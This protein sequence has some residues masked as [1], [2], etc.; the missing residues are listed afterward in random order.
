[1]RDA[2]GVLKVGCVVADDQIVGIN[3]LAHGSVAQW[4]EV[5][6]LERCAA[7]AKQ[8][9]HAVSVGIV[10]RRRAGQVVIEVLFQRVGQLVLFCGA[11]VTVVPD[12]HRSIGG[13]HFRTC[14]RL[15]AQ[16]GFQKQRVTDA[17]HTLDRSAVRRAGK[18]GDLHFQ[19]EKLDALRAVLNPLLAGFK[20]V[21]Y[22]TKQFAADAAKFEVADILGQIVEPAL[23]TTAFCLVNRLAVQAD[24]DRTIRVFDA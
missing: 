21:L 12:L 22:A 20:V 23:R 13:Q 18:V 24:G 5:D 16:D 14:V 15:E 17:G 1:M 11:A 2:S 4:T 10:F 19:T 9:Q 6:L 8:Q 7:E 3:S